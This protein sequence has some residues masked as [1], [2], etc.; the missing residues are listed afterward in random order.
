MKYVWLLIFISLPF[1]IVIGQEIQEYS[2]YDHG[3]GL[4]TSFK[5][6][7]LQDNMATVLI[8]YDIQ[9][10]VLVRREGMMVHYSDSLNDANDPIGA[11][12]PFRSGLRR[13]M[14]IV[15]DMGSGYFGD[16]RDS[17]YGLTICNDAEE[18]CTTLAY[19]PITPAWRS[20]TFPYNSDYGT[21]TGSKLSI[22]NSGTELL[23]YH[24]D[25]SWV[26]PARPLGPG[27]P[28][29]TPL[30]GGGNITGV[31]SY[32]Y[33]YIS[34][35][36]SQYSSPSWKVTVERG[37]VIIDMILP[38]WDTATVAN[39]RLLREEGDGIYRLLTTIPNDNTPM[40][41]FT[42]NVAIGGLNPGDTLAY[43]W[44]NF[45]RGSQPGLTAPGAPTVVLDTALSF[46]TGISMRAGE[47]TDQ[48]RV[49]DTS[50]VAYATV[51][52]DVNGNLSMM[53][54]PT[55]TLIDAADSGEIMD[56]IWKATMTHIAIPTQ[57]GIISKSLMLALRY[58]TSGA[59]WL[60]GNS[61]DYVGLWIFVDSNMN[62]TDEESTPTGNMTLFSPFCSKDALD[63]ALWVDTNSGSV[64]IGQD[65][66]FVPGE[67]PESTCYVP[68][69]V[70]SFA[71]S[72]L[73]GHGSRLYATGDLSHVNRLF[74]SEFGSPS[75]WPYDKFIEVGSHEG[76]W[77]TGLINISNNELIMFR[78]NSVWGLSGNSFYQF[79]LDKVAPGVGLEA[80]RTL[81][82]GRIGIFFVHRSGVYIINQPTPMSLPIQATVDAVR[83]YIQDS[84]GLV[85][86][87]EY[88]WSVGLS[89][90]DP[91]VTYIFSPIPTPHWKS[92]SFGVRDAI[93]WDWDT[94]TVD[95]NSRRYI[96][97]LDNDSL[98]QWGD[99]DT[100]TTDG[101]RVF[102]AKYQSKA[103]LDNGMNRE[104][105]F[106]V[107]IDGS[108]TL[109][110]LKVFV[111]DKLGTDTL[112][113]QMVAVDFSDNKKDRVIVNK[114]LKDCTIRF[115]DQGAGDYR[116]EGYVIGWVPWDGGRMQ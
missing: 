8:D 115:E 3:G 35:G 75:V 34:P 85:I 90:S 43:P 18:V 116:I 112:F 20:S 86:G 44:G 13:K 16:A 22:A 68:D 74:F 54:P 50:W 64:F 107:D 23:L 2:V 10:G 61:E 1:S 100:C 49:T 41:T 71:P 9:D 109:D 48:G 94:S 104:K 78:Q 67:Y 29:A 19:S 36:I 65:F 83:A 38:H 73:V 55:W 87:D 102:I 77:F 5:N 72:A 14:L 82:Q 69:S 53:S 88:W 30:N 56:A 101:G 89:G 66:I 80:P 45:P 47:W 111:I 46:F 26:Y 96:L 57:D 12:I 25:S 58:P 79:S 114:I 70:I 63:E 11:L 21:L 31:V 106:Y 37:K 33:Y 32:K 17:L 97:A 28:R 84:W 60:S 40:E 113:S 59:T 81:S 98:Y 110:S 93:I 24:E 42:D 76:D 51:F 27:Q 62:L 39:I 99:C 91:E 4:V 15:R 52:E 103:F 108:G 105:I 95:F 6:T 92:Y 7:R